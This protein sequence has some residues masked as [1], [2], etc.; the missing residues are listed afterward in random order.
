MFVSSLQGMILVRRLTALAALALVL[1]MIFLGSALACAMPG[2]EVAG[3]MDKDGMNMGG[4]APTSEQL[5]SHDDPECSFP[6]A[7][8]GCHTATCAAA[9]VASA[10]VTLREPLVLGSSVAA[11]KISLPLSL[12]QEPEPPPPRA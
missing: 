5:P 1:Q 3:A 8:G 4:S 10:R 9:A 7:P 11:A 6:W 12:T 2:M